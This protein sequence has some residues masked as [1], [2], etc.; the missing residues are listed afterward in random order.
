MDK[1]ENLADKLEFEK[2]TNLI[3]KPCIE[4]IEYSLMYLKQGHKQVH[5]EKTKCD[6]IHSFLFLNINKNES[7]ILENEKEK[8]DFYGVLEEKIFKK[9]ESTKTER[10]FSDELNMKK[11]IT[12]ISD[13]YKKVIFE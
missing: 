11:E 8:T 5:L 2:N 6:L 7:V 9:N 3:L 4:C 13:T 1:W 10:F 12:C